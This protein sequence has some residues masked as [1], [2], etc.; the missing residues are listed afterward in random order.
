M[1][2]IEELYLT[3]ERFLLHIYSNHFTKLLWYFE[4]QQ[5]LIRI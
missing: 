2:F 5:L 4:V 3:I 1:L